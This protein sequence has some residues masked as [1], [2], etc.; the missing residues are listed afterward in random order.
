MPFFAG[1]AAGL[2]IAVSFGPSFLYMMQTAV[3]HGLRPSLL[4]AT[5]IVSCDLLLI[6]IA[7][8][9]MGQILV[10]GTASQWI[11]LTGGMVLAVMGLV[12]LF[13]PG[14]T[15]QEPVL[16]GKAD[17]WKLIFK[18]FVLNLSNPFNFIFWIGV[19]GLATSNL[20]DTHQ[21]VAFLAGLFT[22]E[23][24]STW[25]KCYLPSLLGRK[26]KPVLLKTVNQVV[27]GAFLAAGVYLLISSLHFI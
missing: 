14:K 4:I 12:N 10:H 26:I 5:G 2:T 15:A 23:I 25:L 1:L 27:G 20:T 18:G 13:R 11:G 3:K 7:F 17:S 9:G 24:F 22:T 19:A 16:N 6:L 8:T 21:T